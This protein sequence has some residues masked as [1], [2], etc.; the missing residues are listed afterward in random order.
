MSR[1]TL[2]TGAAGFAGSHVLDLITP[3]GADV[4]A[5]HRPGGSPPSTDGSVRWQAVDVLDRLSVRNAIQE[6]RPGAVYHCAGAAHVGQAWNATTTTLATNVLGTHHLIE[7]L[8]AFSPDAHVLNPSSALVY[9]PSS[10]PLDEQQPLV[11]TSPYGLSKLVQELL[12][13]GHPDGPFVH[14]ARPFNHFGP[15]QNPSFV[16]SGFARTIALIEAGRMRP[17]IQVGNL[18][19]LRDLT[20]VRDTV[21]AYQLIL[22]RG[23]PGRP[24][25]VC[26]GRPIKVGHLLDM[27]LR[28]AHVSIRVVVDPERYRPND[29]PIVQGNPARIREELGWTPRIAVEQTIEDLLAFWRE[30]TSA[31]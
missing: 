25:N 7:A 22:E 29:S 11:P 5:W 28:R 30:R 9:T 31:A 2:V 18:E 12:G 10:A 6:V 3:P 19:P 24:Y 27:M 20:D 17:E 4:V 1:P 13:D 15:R 8:R 16:G 23:T 26:S 21:R 14:I